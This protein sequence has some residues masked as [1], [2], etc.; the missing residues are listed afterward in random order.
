MI[1]ELRTAHEDA[2]TDLF[3]KQAAYDRALEALREEH[4]DGLREAR[5]SAAK[6]QKAL[7]DAEAAEA[8][9]DRPDGEAVAAALG[10]E[11]A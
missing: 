3:Q 6:A 9:R 4:L 7:C 11:L 8:L 1:E 10:L 5:D 2:E